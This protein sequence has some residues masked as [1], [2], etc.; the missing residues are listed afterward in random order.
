MKK[1]NQKKLKDYTNKELQTHI[2]ALTNIAN[3]KLAEINIQ[4]IKSKAITKELDILTSKGIL[5]KKGY[6]VLGFRGKTKEDLIEQARELEY[7]STWK[8]TEKTAKRTRTDLAK[9]RAFIA[10]NS[11]N[12]QFSFEEWR[13]MVDLMG[14]SSAKLEMFRMDSDT[15]R[16][17]MESAKDEGLTINIRKEMDD[18]L[19]TYKDK[20][21]SSED[22]TDLLRNRIYEQSAINKIERSASLSNMVKS[23]ES[24]HPGFTLE[25]AVRQISKENKALD[26]NTIIKKLK[27]M[28]V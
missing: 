6:A 28:M 10:N 2:R 15:V 4:G 25:D 19:K 21:L 11:E 9:Y 3:E 14:L 16:L 12:K 20:G 18:L 1:P 5:G 23:Y 27:E 7:F 17:M 8:G 22:M 13:M 24:T 26:T